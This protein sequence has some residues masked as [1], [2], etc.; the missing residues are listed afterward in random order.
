ME[1][2]AE[3]RRRPE[4]GRPEP[5]QSAPKPAT[6]ARPGRLH[7][8]LLGLLP[9][10]LVAVA[11]AL[12]AAFGA[13]GLGERAGPPVEE[14]VVER[15]VLRPGQIE[16]FVRNDGPDAVRVAQVIVNDAYV[17]FAITDDMVGRL[18]GATLTIAYPWVEGEAYEIALLTSLG[19]T[20]GH[21]IPAPSRR[22]RPASA[23]TDSWR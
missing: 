10:A 15:T 7:V 9:V 18:A 17:D 20:I 8:A 21:A 5:G 4:P 14:L 12:F 23:S 11:A 2:H 13:P 22:R 6:A 3:A 1:A 16:L 19:A